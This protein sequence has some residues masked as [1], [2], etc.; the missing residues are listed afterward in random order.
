MPNW[1]WWCHQME[2]FPALLAL[3]ERNPPV[4]GGF[5]SQ[6]P[7]TGSLDVFFDLRLNKRL[8]KQPGRRWFETLSRS[9]WRHCN[10]RP[11]VEANFSSFTTIPVKVHTMIHISKV[12]VADVDE[13]KGQETANYF[14]SV[15]GKDSA[16]FIK[17]DVTNRADFESK[18]SGIYVFL[19]SVSYVSCNKKKSL[20]HFTDIF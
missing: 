4:I 9:L 15:F 1:P 16:F 12:C 6:R 10:G 8:N 3:C 5:P 17:C 14:C 11:N 7:V 20:A 18:A 2:T 13:V 19:H